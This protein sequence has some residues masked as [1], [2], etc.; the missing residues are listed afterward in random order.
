MVRKH[1]QSEGVRGPLQRVLDNTS[2]QPQLYEAN[3]NVGFNANDFQWEVH[4]IVSKRA[5]AGSVEYLVKWVDWD[6]DTWVAAADLLGSQRF[7][8]AF[9]ATFCSPHG[10]PA[11][12]LSDSDSDSDSISGSHHQNQIPAIRVHAPLLSDVE[13]EEEEEQQQQECC[14]DIMEDI[15]WEVEQILLKRNN[16]GV[17][18][19]FVKWLKGHTPVRFNFIKIYKWGTFEGADHFFFWNSLFFSF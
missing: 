5:S 7:I 15:N 6:S 16:Q 3:V 11:A 19:Y 13:E 17:T 1:V 18:E 4:S 2:R 14:D 9:E 8:D 12:I 10:A